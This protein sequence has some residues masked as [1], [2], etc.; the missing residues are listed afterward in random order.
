M[1][2]LGPL[3]VPEAQPLVLVAGHLI[4][5]AVLWAWAL[6]TD[7]GDQ[8]SLTRFYMRVWLLFFLEYALMPAAVLAG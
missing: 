3:A 1:V 5:L 4:A 8:E 6:R 7:V 2:V